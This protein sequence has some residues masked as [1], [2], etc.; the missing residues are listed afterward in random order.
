MSQATLNNS[1]TSSTPNS[2]SAS[3]DGLPHAPA[4]GNSPGKGASVPINYAN[5]RTTPHKQGINFRLILFIAVVGLPLTGVGWLMVRNLLS[6]GI[7]WHGDYAEV[8]LKALGNFPFNESNGTKDDVPQR[9]RDL[10]GKKV[11]L[12]GFM[13][14]PQSAGDRGNEFQFVYNVQKCCFSGP[15]LVQERVYCHSHAD[16]PLYPVSDFARVVGILHVRVVRDK[17]GGIH[18]VFDLDVQHDEDLEG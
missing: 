1:T 6:K 13:F 17:S 18:S 14:S 8:N 11:E 5:R 9:W 12:K 3:K 2:S 10:D 15:P 7:T 16:I 4:L